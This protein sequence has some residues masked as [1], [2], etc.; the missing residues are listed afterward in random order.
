MWSLS[1][2]LYMKFTLGFH[3]WSYLCQFMSKVDQRQ[4]FVK[5]KSVRTLL[6]I[7]CLA[8][9]KS[10]VVIICA[11]SCGNLTKSEIGSR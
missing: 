1:V 7:A 3:M 8:I 11:S 5:L 4:N 2:T 9:M 6:K 10:Y